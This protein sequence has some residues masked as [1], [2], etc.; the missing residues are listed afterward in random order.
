M[1][2]HSSTRYK[3]ER[4]AFPELGDSGRTYSTNMD[5]ALPISAPSAQKEN[6]NKWMHFLNR[7][8]WNSTW[9]K[10]CG[11]NHSSRI[12]RHILRTCEEFTYLF[13]ASLRTTP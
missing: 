6:D 11:R 7:Q 12:L 8:A 4:T 2:T 3:G 9:P 10:T 1:S 5:I 13:M